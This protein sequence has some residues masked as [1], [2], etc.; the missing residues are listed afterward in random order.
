MITNLALQNNSIQEHI[1]HN[2]IAIAPYDDVEHE[3]IRDKYLWIE[4]GVPIL[5]IIMR[6]A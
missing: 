4:S 1:H 5:R 6:C 3:H 2:I